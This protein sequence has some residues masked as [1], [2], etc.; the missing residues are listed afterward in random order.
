MSDDAVEYKDMGLKE[1]L[2]ILSNKVKLPSAK[3]GILGSNSQRP[4]DNPE[5][6]TN[7]Q[8][9]L[10]HEL[11]IGE[12]QRSF[13]RMPITM[14]LNDELNKNGAFDEETI[15]DLLI[16]KEGK[17]FVEKIAITAEAISIDSFDTGG[18]GLWKPSNM[19]NKKVHQTLVETGQL[20]DSVTYEVEE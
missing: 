1:L 3:V 12:N 9:G 10:F 11:G 13:L 17:K 15:K 19:K 5:Q 6:L 16:S 4:E 7:A 8:I 18:F 14:K 20:R 2:E